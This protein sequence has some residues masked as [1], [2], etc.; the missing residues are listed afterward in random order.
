M[1]VLRACPAPPDI[2]IAAHQYETAM[3][4]SDDEEEQPHL[5][6]DTSTPFEVYYLD[7][8]GA[9]AHI[10]ACPLTIFRGNNFRNSLPAIGAAVGIPYPHGTFVD[11]HKTF[12]LDDELVLRFPIP[13]L[14]ERHRGGPPKYY[15]LLGL[16]LDGDSL[17]AALERLDGGTRPEVFLPQEHPADKWAR[18][19]LWLTHVQPAETWYRLRGIG[20]EFDTKSFHPARSA[21]P[22][23][24][25]A[26]TCDRLNRYPAT[27]IKD[28]QREWEQIRRSDAAFYERK[29]GN[30][31]GAGAVGEYEDAEEENMEGDSGDGTMASEDEEESEI[32]SEEEGGPPEMI[33]NKIQYSLMGWRVKENIEPRR[34]E[35]LSSIRKQNFIGRPHLDERCPA[36]PVE[37]TP[38]GMLQM[39]VRISSMFCMCID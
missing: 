1:I 8:E 12:V 16:T 30:G 25:D 23:N 39:E 9:L 5:L 22:D 4:A 14:R 2:E 32:D 3:A 38:D 36:L 27:I 17:R 29:Y 31:D 37:V 13:C 15:G 7:R 10:L 33:R 34:R 24:P 18:G 21:A 28:N 6:P 11:A 20:A 35:V 26:Y 19:I